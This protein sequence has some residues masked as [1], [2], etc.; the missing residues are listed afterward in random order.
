MELLGC[1]LIVRQKQS[2]ETINIIISGVAV[3]II[4]EIIVRF[5]LGP[6]HRFKEIKGEIASILLFHANNYDQEYAK[7]DDILGSKG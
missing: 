3:F 2:M 5:F 4:G 1:L 6:L 7:L